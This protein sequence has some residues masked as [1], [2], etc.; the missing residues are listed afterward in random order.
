MN[1]RKGIVDYHIHKASRMIV[2]LAIEH[3]VKTIVIGDF[4]GIKQKNKIK[5]FVQIPHWTLK[6]Q[7]KYKARKEG[8]RVI[9]REESYTSSVSSVDLEPV[10]EDYS[11]K[12]RRVVR[13]LFKS[14]FGYINSDING[15]LNILRKSIHEKNIPRLIELVR[16]KGFRDNPIR[17]LTI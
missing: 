14:S 12:S 6:H 5:Y 3:D 10:N 1:K 9:I 7:I 15:S 13:G 4:K 2:N 8:I 17:F 16:D 11:N